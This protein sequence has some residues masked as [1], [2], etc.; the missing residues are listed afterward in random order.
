MS[1]C[2]VVNTHNRLSCSQRGTAQERPLR[3]PVISVFVGVMGL[4]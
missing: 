3:K 1:T 4:E 2:R